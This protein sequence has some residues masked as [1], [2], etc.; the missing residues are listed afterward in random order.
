MT[1]MH[2]AVAPATALRSHHPDDERLALLRC[3]LA[4]RSWTQDAGQRALL[5]QV[6]AALR[7]PGLATLDEGQWTLLADETARYLDFRRQQSLERLLH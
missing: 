2:S 1:L 3:L 6:L 7:T 4:D 5:Q